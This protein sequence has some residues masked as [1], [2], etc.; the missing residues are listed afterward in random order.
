[1]RLYHH[2]FSSNARRAVMTAIHLG[3]DVELV[4][5]ELQKLEQRAPAYLAKNLFW[6]GST[7]PFSVTSGSL[8]DSIRNTFFLGCVSAIYYWRARTEEAHLLREDAKY[9]EYHA[10]MAEHGLIT[11]RLRKALRK[12]HRRSPAALQPAE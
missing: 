2:P 11:S 9:R 10:W 7:L 5:V 8:V 3:V 1:M 4:H 12:L 6:W